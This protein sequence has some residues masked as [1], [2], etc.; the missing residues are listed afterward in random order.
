MKKLNVLAIMVIVVVLLMANESF[1]R[2]QYTSVLGDRT[3]ALICGGDT[4]AHTIT[5]NYECEITSTQGTDGVPQEECAISEEG[6][7]CIYCGGMGGYYPVPGKANTGITR[8]A[9]F[10]CKNAEPEEVGYCYDGECIYTG[11][12]ACSGTPARYVT[13]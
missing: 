4:Q 8:Q 9:N 2:G 11:P 7:P 3:L 13:E 10:A 12:G 6:T 5:G 1:C